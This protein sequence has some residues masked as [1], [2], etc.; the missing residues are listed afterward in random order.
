MDDVNEIFGTK[1]QSAVEEAWHRE[2]NRKQF[3]IIR[4]KSPTSVTVKG[5]SYDLNLMPQAMKDHYIMYDIEQ[6]QKV[7]FGSTI[8]IPYPRAMLYVKHR[9]DTIVNYINAKM[10]DEFIA[11]RRKKGF[12]DYKDKAEENHE[13]YETQ[14]YPKGNDEEL[15]AELYDQM[16]MG[17]TIRA[18]QDRPP[19]LDNPRAGEMDMR[20]N[21]IRVMESLSR[22]VVDTSKDPSP[23]VNPQGTSAPPIPG[24]QTTNPFAQMNRQLTP[25][26]ITNEQ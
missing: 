20:P 25:E 16:W 8:D 6:Y 21:E 5:V 11:N 18:A 3:D 2:Q 17:M 4:V 12:P 26:E 23:F 24:Q 15:I 10:H 1:P 9:K 13:T 19:N 22:K 7:P 14:E